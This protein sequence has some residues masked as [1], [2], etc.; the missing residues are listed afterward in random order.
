VGD[1]RA[2]PQSTASADAVLL[3]GPL[4][5]LV[6]AEDRHRALVE[7]RR[8]LRPSGVL[9]AAA[10]SR[11]MAVLDWASQGGLSDS[12]AEKLRPVLATGIHDPSLGFT[13]AYFHTAAEL[14]NEVEAA[15]FDDVRV[16]GIEGPAWTIA[17]TEIDPGPKF[18]SALACAELTEDHPEI[19]NASAHLMA[20]AIAS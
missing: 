15:G 16:V 7:A 10:I 19:T 6:S 8:V 4:Y 13:D 9:I 17:D 18:R 1:A 12:V 20:I 14:Q 5:H 3:L 11:F 2:L